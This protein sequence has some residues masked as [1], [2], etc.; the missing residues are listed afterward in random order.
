[1]SHPAPSG[2]TPPTP[3]HQDLKVVLDWLLDHA[4]LTAVRFRDT[5][6]WT[7]RGL[8]A[9]ALLWAWADQT[10]LTERF[11]SARKIAIL[12]C[13]LSELT[14]QTSQAFLKMLRA[15]TVTLALAV[16]AALRRRM[17]EDLADRFR[18]HGFVVFGVDGSRL[19][20]PRSVS[21]QQRFAA[22]SKPPS[23][24]ARRSAPT[25]AAH[26]KKAD[27]PQLWLTVMFHVATGLL[28]DWRLGPSDSS[29]REHLLQMIAAWPAGALVTADAGFVGYLYWKALL[30]S[31]R[32]LL[33]RVGANVRLVRG[34]GYTRERAGRVY[35]WPD[36]EAARH[37]PPLVLRLI[38]ARGPRHP[39]YLVTSVL[40]EEQLT[41]AQVLE[42][43][44]L[45]WGVE[46]CQADS[47]S[48][49]GWCG[50]PGGGYDRRR[51]A[52]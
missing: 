12:S 16:V 25:A 9:A 49:D 31:E 39:I 37:Q 35:L 23:H 43:Y 30:D 20:L 26:R 28:W 18:L 29:E 52:A 38:V 48:S 27:N 19:E 36:R 34:L 51:R 22:R 50:T 41:T 6:T 44:G 11:E 47:T 24:S 4:D 8:I 46:T 1:M 3:H 14:A 21:N 32:H 2:L 13:G 15:W 42:L 10:A 17:Q 45:R 5:C 7:P 40:E 33:I